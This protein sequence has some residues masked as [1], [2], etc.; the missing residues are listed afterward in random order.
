M[1]DKDRSFGL[2]LQMACIMTKNKNSPTLKNYRMTLYFIIEQLILTDLCLVLRGNCSDFITQIH[3][4]PR[5]E[6]N[7]HLAYQFY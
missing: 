1:R 2:C 7:M 5:K 3:L 4:M 6:G